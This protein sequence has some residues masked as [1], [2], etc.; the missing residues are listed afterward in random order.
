MLQTYCSLKGKAYDFHFKS[1]EIGQMVGLYTQ[2]FHY[3]LMNLYK[4]MQKQTCKY[5][6]D[7]NKVSLFI[8]Y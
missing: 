5:G 4:D 1:R 2:I 6:H 7:N 8:S 3:F